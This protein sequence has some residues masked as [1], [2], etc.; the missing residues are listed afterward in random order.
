MIGLIPKPY[1][2]LAVAFLAFSA[3]T[4]AYFKGRAD[5]KQVERSICDAGKSKAAEANIEIKK[6]QDDIRANYPD[7]RALLKRLRDGSYP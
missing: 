3:L 6:K 2:I 4:G 5:G 1:L 7:N